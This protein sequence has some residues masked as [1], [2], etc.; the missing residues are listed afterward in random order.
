[1]VPQQKNIANKNNVWD[2]LW[3]AHKV[4]FVIYLRSRQGQAFSD[5]VSSVPWFFLLSPVNL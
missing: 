3:L 4:L 5:R 2:K 1:M